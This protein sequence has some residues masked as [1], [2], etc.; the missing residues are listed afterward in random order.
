MKHNKVRVGSLYIY[1][2]NVLDRIDR[3]TGLTDGTLVKVIQPHGCPRN[4]T[5]GH[6]FVGDAVRG[7]FIRL[8]HC[9]SLHAKKGLH[10]VSKVG[11]ENVYSI[12]VVCCASKSD[13]WRKAVMKKSTEVRKLEKEIAK[14]GDATGMLTTQLRIA[15]KVSRKIAAN[16]THRRVTK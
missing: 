6:C 14:H 5:M 9:N 15:R 11:T 1:H 13:S 12:R 8:V 3:R 7:H 10:C 16:E 2:A 4:G